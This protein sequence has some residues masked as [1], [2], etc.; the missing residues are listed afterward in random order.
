M[1]G[2]FFVTCFKSPELFSDVIQSISEG[3]QLGLKSKPFLTQR[4]EDRFDEKLVDLQKELEVGSVSDVAAGRFD[5]DSLKPAP[6]THADV[7]EKVFE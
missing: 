1:L 4:W 2:E 5:P 3:Y 6:P 7:H